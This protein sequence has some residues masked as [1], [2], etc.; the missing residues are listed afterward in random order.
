M[1]FVHEQQASQKWCLSSSHWTACAGYKKNI[2]ENTSSVE[3]GQMLKHDKLNICDFQQ[4]LYFHK[5]LAGSL[6]LFVFHYYIFGYCDVQT[7]SA[8]ES[9]RHLIWHLS[10]FVML[11]VYQQVALMS[12][13]YLI[14]IHIRRFRKDIEIIV[15]N[16]CV[17]NF[18][19][20]YTHLELLWL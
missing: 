20:I 4:Q 11:A 6:H 16:K 5:L 7:I 8:V 18:R 10:T 13:S 3:S 15:R 17:F 14:H 19:L 2:Y 9:Y 12:S 1:L